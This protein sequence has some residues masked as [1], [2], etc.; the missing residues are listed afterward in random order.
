MCNL[1]S[2]TTAQEA[3]RQLFDV[4]AANDRLGNQAPQPAIFPKYTAP[5]VRMSDTSER[6]LVAMHWGFLT[7]Q[8]SKKTGKPIK[9]AAWNN[10]RDD[11]VRSAGLW[12]ASFAA[13]RCLIPASSFCEAKGRK[14]ATYHW[15]ALDEDRSPFAFAGFWR[16]DLLAEGPT[17]TI[18]TTTPNDLV[19]PIHPSR[20]PVILHPADFDAW[21]T[22]TPE[23]A[24][25]LMRAFPAE[26]MRIVRS[27]IGET[28]D[29]TPASGL[30]G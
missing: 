2:N 11:K 5:V 7:P 30:P 23:V 20:M 28:A 18:V 4:T 15:F 21:L 3:M 24:A 1:Y 8:V 9:P 10:A 25:D 14:P 19:R 6:E 16:D 22:G 27:G 29:P 17:Y 12:R 26:N 13:R